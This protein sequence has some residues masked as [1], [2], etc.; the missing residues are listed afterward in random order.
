M[1]QMAKNIPTSSIA[2]PSKIY[3]NLGFWLENMQSGNRGGLTVGGVSDESAKDDEHVVDVQLTHDL[4]GVLLAGRHGL[5][6]PRD[7]RV[8]PRVVVHQ[9][10]A[11]GHGGDLG[12]MLRSQFAAIFGKK[13]AFFQNTNDLFSAKMA[14]N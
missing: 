9:D 2:R 12:S 7:V 1:Y 6:H 11:V 13:S 10:C 14:F 4:V 5:A 3:P 8:V